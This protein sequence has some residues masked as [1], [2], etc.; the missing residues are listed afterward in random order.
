MGLMRNNRIREWREKRGFHQ[1]ELATLVGY[2]QSYLSHLESGRREV[3]DSKLKKIADALNV[4]I[5]D[6]LEQNDVAHVEVVGYVRRRPFIEAAMQQTLKKVECPRDMDPKTT[7][8]IGIETDEYGAIP[9]EN[10]L[11]Y[12]G[13]IHH[14]VPISFISPY[15]RLCLIKIVDREQC[16]LATLGPGDDFGTYHVYSGS[17]KPFLANQRIEYTRPI[18]HAKPA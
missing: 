9:Y 1:S 5:S 18:E 15:P 2:K 6:L 3:S 16:L 7:Q 10:W 13:Q 4:K 17:K 8:A 11:V 12:V 14:G